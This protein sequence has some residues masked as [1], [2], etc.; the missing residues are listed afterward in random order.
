MDDES[1]AVVVL[2][3]VFSIC[4]CALIGYALYMKYLTFAGGFVVGL[5]ILA[6]LLA[7]ILAKVAMWIIQT[8][9]W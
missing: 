9:S 3:I 7:Y 2:T 8:D 5:V 1:K 4:G 6:P